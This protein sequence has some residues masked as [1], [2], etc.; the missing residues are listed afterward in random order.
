MVVDLFELF[1]TQEGE[2]K[3]KYEEITITEKV[4]YWAP[5]ITNL[6]CLPLHGQESCKFFTSELPRERCGALPLPLSRYPD[7]V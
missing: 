5:S 2:A 1:A 6:R 7:F 3:Q 4:K